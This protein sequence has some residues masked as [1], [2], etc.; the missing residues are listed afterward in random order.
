[1]AGTYPQSD[2][3]TY[4]ANRLHQQADSIPVPD[5]PLGRAGFNIGSYGT[6]YGTLAGA[7]G[8][9]ARQTAN[10]AGRLGY[11]PGPYGT[12]VAAA[13]PGAADGAGTLYRDL[14]NRNVNPDV[15]ARWAVGAG[16]TAGLGGPLVERGL[17]RL[18]RLSGLADT[19]QT[20]L[21]NLQSPLVRGAVK[22][23]G[24]AVYDAALN[25]P[26]TKV[27]DNI[28]SLL[29]EQPWDPMY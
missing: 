16:T 8:Q 12:S 29:P 24:K 26:E 9:A 17:G 27:H 3:L 13:T 14:V 11:K 4:A 7:G 23:G 19:Y 15:A 6:Q 18:A 25:I 28:R 1:M 21:N 2:N 20:S 10:L 22:L 5:S